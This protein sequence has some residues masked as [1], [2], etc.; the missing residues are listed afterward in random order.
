MMA[1]NQK[2]TD[3]E[4]I[5]FIRKSDNHLLKEGLEYALER[6]RYKALREEFFNKNKEK[7][8]MIILAE[9]VGE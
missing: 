8:K 6:K 1:A 7:W 4:L 5:D 3:E 9:G 2:M